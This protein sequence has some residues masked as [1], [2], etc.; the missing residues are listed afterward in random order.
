MIPLFFFNEKYLGKTV[1]GRLNKIRWRI[2]I[3]SAHELIRTFS[4]SMKIPFPMTVC[5]LSKHVPDAGSAA[6]CTTKELPPHG[7]H[8]YYNPGV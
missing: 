8:V 7:Q 2:V 6:S 3:P 1:F 5:N 4:G